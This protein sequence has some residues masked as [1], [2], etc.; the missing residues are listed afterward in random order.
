MDDWHSSNREANSAMLEA[1]A[2]AAAIAQHIAVLTGAGV[3]AESGIPTFREAQTGLWAKYDPVML[4]SY[5]GFM[6]DPENV[7]RWYDMRRQKVREARPNPGHEAFARWEQEWRRRGRHF[8]LIT[9]NIDD[10]HG[11]AGSSDI[12]ELHGNIWMVRGIDAPHAAAFRLDDCPLSEIPPRSQDGEMLRPHVVWFGEML[13]EKNLTEAF[14]AAAE[15]DVM[16]VAGTSSLVYPAAAIPIMAKREGAVVIEVNPEETGL[17]AE[18]DYSLRGTSG[19]LLPA[20]YEHAK[21]VAD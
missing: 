18:A 10:L 21:R 15:C 3:S 13:D 11:L 9:Q 20:M 17:S 19:E 7:W 16:I 6:Q 5:E 8:Q 14:R 12:I 4:A 2:E 1:A